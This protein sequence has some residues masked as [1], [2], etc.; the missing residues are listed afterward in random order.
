[1]AAVKRPIDTTQCVGSPFRIARRPMAGMNWAVDWPGGSGFLGRIPGKE[2]GGVGKNARASAPTRS[3]YCARRITSTNLAGT[4][5][6]RYRHRSKEVAPPNGGISS[7]IARDS[8]RVFA[9]LRRSA[10]RGVGFARG[11]SARP[12]RLN[13][14]GGCK[15][16]DRNESM[17]R[18]PFSNS[19][20]GL[21][22]G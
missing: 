10:R 5:C 1:M 18:W 8:G 20:A 6:P 9:R 14:Q 21:S 16:A 13:A 19:A 2:G 11:T 22:R 12:Y 4:T 15:E 17:R 7:H 3:P